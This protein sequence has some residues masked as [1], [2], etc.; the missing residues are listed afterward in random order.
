[1]KKPTLT[2]I[3]TWLILVISVSC[4][5][6]LSED[7]QLQQNI[8]MAIANAADLPPGGFVVTATSGLVTISGS[9]DCEDC[10]GL[11]TPGGIDNIQQSLGA[12]VRAV[13]GVEQVQFSLQSP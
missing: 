2:L 11:R 5:P 6:V 4:S 8:E 9:L 1:M 10:G 3:L 7:E 12:V 13:P